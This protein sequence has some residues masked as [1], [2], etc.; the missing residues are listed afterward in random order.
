M[1]KKIK[2]ALSDVYRAPE[3]ERKKAFLKKYRRRELGRRDFL[4][5]HAGYI[6]WWNW[7]ASVLLFC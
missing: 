6:R 2:T 4:L 5:T 7:M 3:P 1:D